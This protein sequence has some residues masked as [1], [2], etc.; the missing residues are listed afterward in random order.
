MS[1]R[2]VDDCTRVRRASL[3]PSVHE[4]ESKE[5][6]A[7]IRESRSARARDCLVSLSREDG[8]PKYLC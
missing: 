3:N 6:G 8:L 7:S 2:G 4:T 5:Q 1:Y